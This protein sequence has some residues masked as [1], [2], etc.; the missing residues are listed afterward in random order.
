[1]GGEKQTGTTVNNTTSTP[2]PTPE[3]TRLNQLDLQLREQNQGALG[4]VQG[5][6]LNLANLLLKGQGLPGYLGS[7]TGGVDEA[8][9]QSIVDKSL[10][11]IAPSFQQRGLLDS[12]VRASI[13]ARNAG[14]IRRNSAEFNINNLMQLLNLATGNAAQ[15]QTPV[16]AQAADL[17][18]RLGGLR[19]INQSGTQTTST[20]SNQNPF[21]NAAVGGLAGGIGTGLG[22]GFAKKYF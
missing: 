21:L 6:S 9:T 1:M 20:R 8:T 15:V 22:G 14:D 18:S 12:G 17:G 3:E 5:N 13:S 4:E 16:L 11:D 7:L 2:T 19:T 10:R